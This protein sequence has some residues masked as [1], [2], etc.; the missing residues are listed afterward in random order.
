MHD[1]QGF[2]HIAL[3]QTLDLFGDELDDLAGDLLV[4]IALEERKGDASRD[5]MRAPFLLALPIALAG[6]Q[7]A[8]LR[9]ESLAFPQ[10]HLQAIRLAAPDHRRFTIHLLHGAEPLL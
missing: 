5:L 10:L 9:L 4:G 3:R 2:E 8:N 6:L 7:L 1:G